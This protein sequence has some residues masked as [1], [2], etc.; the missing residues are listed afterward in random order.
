MNSPYKTIGR[1]VDSHQKASQLATERQL[2]WAP[3]VKVSEAKSKGNQVVH[4][5]NKK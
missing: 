2:S 1:V 4:P 3:P 5:S